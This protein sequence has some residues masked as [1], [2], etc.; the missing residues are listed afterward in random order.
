M[1]LSSFRS[2]NIFPVAALQSFCDNS[3][4][5]FILGYIPM[6]RY[7]SSYESH[8]LF[9]QIST[10]FSCMLDSVDATLKGCCIMFSSFKGWCVFSWLTVTLLEYPFGSARLLFFVRAVL[11]QV[12]TCS[13][14]WLL[15]QA[16]VLISQVWLFWGVRW[17]PKMLREVSPLWMVWNSNTVNSAQSLLPQFSALEQVISA[18]FLGVLPHACIGSPRPRTHTT[19]SHKTHPS[20]VPALKILAS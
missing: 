20:Q 12:W 15:L 3:N 10:N 17:N 9:F 6:D 4:I 7:F 2:L 1:A 11:F 13:S 8:F 5:W 14:S 16:V 19:N 18:R